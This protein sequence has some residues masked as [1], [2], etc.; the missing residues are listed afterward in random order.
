M[1]GS[2]SFAN[3]ELNLVLSF[4]FWRWNRVAESWNL[5]SWNLCERIGRFKKDKKS[6]GRAVGTTTSIG[7]DGFH[8]VFKFSTCGV[9][10]FAL[11]VKML[12]LKVLREHSPGTRPR[13]LNQGMVIKNK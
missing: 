11:V 7:V 8:V 12:R 3:V 9:E 5:L 13:I 4:R 10:K 2:E 6:G 1:C